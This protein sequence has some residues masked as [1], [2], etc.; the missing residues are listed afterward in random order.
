MIDMHSHVLPG[1]DDGASDVEESLSML[2]DSKKQGISIVVATPHCVVHDD[3][4]ILDSIKRRQEA[5]CSLNKK[6]EE[7]NLKI[8]DI[9]LGFE[10]YLDVDV[11]LFTDFRK[12]CI[13]GTNCMLVELPYRIWTD[14][15]LEFLKSLIDKGI[16]PIIAHVERY[17]VFKH[18]FEKILRV[19]DIVFQVNSDS[20]LSI[21]SRRRI[22]KVLENVAICVAGSDMHN[23]ETRKCSLG[24][25]KKIAEEKFPEYADAVFH[26]NAWKI[27]RAKK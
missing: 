21:S 26:R 4:M 5:Y 17:F 15:N 25:A 2:T 22:K 9:K 20:F 27:L 16:K 23:T 14:M 10:V 24:A 13:E 11:T 12:L 18:N 19:N 3:D 1:V 7:S 6:A 8:P